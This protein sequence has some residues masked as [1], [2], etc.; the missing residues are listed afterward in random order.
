MRR[1]IT[2]PLMA[3]VWTG[4]LTA[5]ALATT[6]GLNQIV[7]P[8]VQPAGV[9]SLRLQQ[10]DPNIGNRYQA[11]LELGLTRGLEV[12][13]FQ[14]ASPSEQIF[15]LEGSLYKKGPY[16]LSAGFINWSSMGSAPQ[17][18][19]ET[20]YYHGKYELILGAIRVLTEKQG[21]GG[22]VLSNHETQAILGAAYQVHPRVLL[23]LDYQSG[24]GNFSTAGFTYNITPNLQVNPSIYV[25]NIAP[26]PLYGYVVLTYNIQAWK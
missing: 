7:T 13:L 9:L 3:L 22:S 11:Q 10:Q 23:Q 18:F 16:L 6:K 20:G 17:P 26:H 21:V 14:G 12:A 4:L 19:V 5:P 15:G 24:A 25:A 8:D 2:L 1:K